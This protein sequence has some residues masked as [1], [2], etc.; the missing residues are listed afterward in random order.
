MGYSP[1]GPKELDRADAAQH[2]CM[3]KITVLISPHSAAEDTEAE[4]VNQSS[5]VQK[6]YTFKDLTSRSRL[7]RVCAKYTFTQLPPS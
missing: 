2:A 6:V 4:E 7:R 5:L 3:S 1:W